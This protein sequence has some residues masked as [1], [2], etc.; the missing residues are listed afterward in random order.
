MSSRLTL[1]QFTVLIISAL[2]N[3]QCIR[4]ISFP[5]PF[6]PPLASFLNKVISISPGCYDTEQPKLEMFCSGFERFGFRRKTGEEIRA[7]VSDDEGVG[8]FFCILNP[9]F[10]FCAR[11]LFSEPV[12]PN[13]AV[14]CC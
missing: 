9:A 14:S 5:D 4:V 7:S 13:E 2:F 10:C 3:H 11:L 12:R 1:Q 6:A 8:F